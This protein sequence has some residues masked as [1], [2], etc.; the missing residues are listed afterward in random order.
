MGIYDRDY[1]HQNFQSH[2]RNAPQ[3]RMTF[4]TLT[5][6]VKKLLIIN[7]AVFFLQV[8][9]ADVF[10]TKWFSVW[11]SSWAY[12]LQLWRLIGYQ[13][14]HGSVMHIVFNMLGLFFLGPTLE[15]HWGSRRFIFFYLGCGTAG[16]LFYIIL[17]TIGFLSPGFLVG[18]SGAILGMLAACAILFPHFVVFILFFPVPIRVAA[19][20]GAVIFIF[21]IITKSA[22]AGGEAAH[23]AGMVAGAAY[24]FARPFRAR[25]K[26]KMQSRKWEQNLSKQREIQIELD[27]ILEKVH[28]EGIHSLT[29]KEKH[30]LRRA[31]EQQ[32][33]ANR[34]TRNDY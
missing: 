30:I 16:G 13:F 28:N 1:T 26:L 7:F 5:P 11:P 6:M 19:V 22:N 4:P 29:R 31:T 10:L 14:L 8:M 33:M 9:G 20:A 2:F 3:M 24:V 21:S 12:S 23:L 18:A 27:R 17:V 32:N 34:R 15:Q 25:L